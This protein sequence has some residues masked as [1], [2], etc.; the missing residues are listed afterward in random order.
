ME[1]LFIV[2]S[3]HCLSDKVVIQVMMNLSLNDVMKLGGLC[4]K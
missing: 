2:W 1:Q 3:S 4:N